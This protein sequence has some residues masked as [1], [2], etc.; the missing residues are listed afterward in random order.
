MV[1]GKRTLV[2]KPEFSPNCEFDVYIDGVLQPKISGELYRFTQDTSEHGCCKVKIIVHKGSVTIRS[3]HGTVYYP[4]IIDGRLTKIRMCQDIV[5]NWLAGTDIF[6][7][8]I[9]D[10]GS[11]E[12][13]HY[14]ANGPTYFEAKF[15]YDAKPVSSDV[16]TTL[17]SIRSNNDTNA[18]R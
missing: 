17:K 3:E 11:L 5:V 7:K 4:I 6:P 16:E 2:V 10:G 15:E 9:K 18:R 12:Y 1:K 8:V 14:F 13:L